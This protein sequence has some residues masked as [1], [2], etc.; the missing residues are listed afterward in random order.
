MEKFTLR[1]RVAL[2]AIGS[3]RA[4][5]VLRITNSSS[6]RSPSTRPPSAIEFSLENPSGYYLSKEAAK[7]RAWIPEGGFNYNK[8][9]SI[10][11]DDLTAY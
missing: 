6:L 11:F 5:S 1:A 8:A 10:S 3:P 4:A 9:P 2:A 7:F